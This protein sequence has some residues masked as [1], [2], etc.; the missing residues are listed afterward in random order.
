[1]IILCKYNSRKR[2]CLQI[3]WKTNSPPE[4]ECEI[5]IYYFAAL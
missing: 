1:M 5:V 4:P 2:H 3:A